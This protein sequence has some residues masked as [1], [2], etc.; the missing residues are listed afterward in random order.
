MPLA[1]SS[2]VLG[3]LAS[4]ST[5]IQATYHNMRSLVL[6]NWGERPNHFHLGCNL[7]E[8]L[9]APNDDETH[10]RVVQRINAQVAQWL[11]YVLLNDVRV[12]GPDPGQS[13]IS[14][15]IDFGLR[16]RQEFSSVLEVAIFGA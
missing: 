2:N 9:F 6:T 7:I 10:D 16:G 1:R 11:P 8:F 12:T 13:K 3:A 5:E 14:I 15:V 4:T